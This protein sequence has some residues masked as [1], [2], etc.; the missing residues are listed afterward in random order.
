M[1]RSGELGERPVAYVVVISTVARGV[2]MY[3]VS[4]ARRRFSDAGEGMR[5]AV[6]AATAG[7]G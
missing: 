6:G 3:T 4:G 5:T 2:V 1:E 7:G